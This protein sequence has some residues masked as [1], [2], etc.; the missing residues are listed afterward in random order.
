[1]IILNLYC[2]E[3]IYVLLK[4]ILIIFLLL[5]IKK[6]SYKIYMK[7]INKNTYLPEKLN[8]LFINLI[9]SSPLRDVIIKGT[10]KDCNFQKLYNLITSIHLLF[11]DI[12]KEINNLTIINDRSQVVNLV[13]NISIINEG[14]STLIK[15]INNNF[16]LLN[17]SKIKLKEK[18]EQLFYN[19]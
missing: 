7:K 18:N 5:L 1:M 12:T 9:L 19:N 14:I 15:D 10:Y 2:Y 16:L 8:F 13:N 6:T 11:D 4:K 17:S 3:N